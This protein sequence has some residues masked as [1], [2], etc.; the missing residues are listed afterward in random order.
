[1]RSGKPSFSEIAFVKRKQVLLERGRERFKWL[2]GLRV[3][4]NAR[5]LKNE[6]PENRK[7]KGR[8]LPVNNRSEYG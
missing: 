6:V 7:G 3:R 5:S 1:M 4:R 2:H 8:K